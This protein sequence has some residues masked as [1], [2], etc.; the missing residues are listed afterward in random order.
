MTTPAE[1]QFKDVDLNAVADAA[2]KVVVFV[3]EDGKLDAGA[4]KVNT[5]TRKTLARFVES[6][7]FEKM[8]A[9]DVAP[10]GI[11]CGH[12]GFCGGCGQTGPQAQPRKMRA[13][14]GRNWPRYKMVMIC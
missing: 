6:A 7:A 4:R 14:P 8:A 12:G 13:R 10:L 1:I 9:G 3:D 2:G 5:L 11:S